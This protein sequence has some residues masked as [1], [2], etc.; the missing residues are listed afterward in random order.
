MPISFSSRLLD[1]NALERTLTLSQ[2]KEIRNLDDKTLRYRGVI[3]LFQCNVKE[4]GNHPIPK[5]T[6]FFQHQWKIS[7]K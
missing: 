7:I 1:E 4:C 5:N 6:N 3:F 2:S